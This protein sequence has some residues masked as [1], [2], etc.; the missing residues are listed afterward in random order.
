MSGWWSKLSFLGSS[1]LP[2]LVSTTFDSTS[3]SSTSTNCSSTS[4]PITTTTT[5]TTPIT[6]TTIIN[7]NYNNNNT[8]PQNNTFQPSL[9]VQNS[10]QNP[11]TTNVSM[12]IDDEE[13]EHSTVI[14]KPPLLNEKIK[15]EKMPKYEQSTFIEME[16]NNLYYQ[17]KAPCP[18][19]DKELIDTPTCSLDEYSNEQLNLEEIERI[20]IIK[21]K[22]TGIANNSNNLE[23]IYAQNNVIPGRLMYCVFGK[24]L[25]Q[26][27]PQKRRNP[28][29]R[30]FM[31]LR[32]VISVT[33]FGL[34]LSV[35]LGPF[36]LDWYPHSMALVTTVNEGAK[37]G[38]AFA[39]IGDHF[40][41]S[42]E[43]IKQAL[44]IVAN[45]ICQYNGTKWYNSESC[46]SIHFVNDVFSNLGL[47]SPLNNHHFVPYF[48]NNFGMQKM[49]YYSSKLFD[50]IAQVEKRED[51]FSDFY[52]LEWLV[53][54]DRGELN[55]FAWFLDSLKYF[56]TM[57]GVKDYA[58][59]KAY[60]RA[61]YL[62]DC[63]EGPTNDDSTR[64]IQFFF[65]TSGQSDD[66]SIAKIEFNIQ[67]MTFD[68]PNRN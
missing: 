21:Q 61:F 66:H 67:D 18:Y 24:Y 48:T 30:A 63:K 23:N 56:Q 59:L 9:L 57:E 37:Y 68:K 5:T 10:G 12:A 2:D 50:M 29:T 20:G 15:E 45:V 41:D 62:N 34:H 19:N 16:K 43:R 40:F 27:R 54:K 31:S 3:S 8:T 6:T 44:F 1:R 13:Y 47:V 64:E 32:L 39:I 28:S 52:N 58:L 35:L 65:T 49:Y 26:Q 22:N 60:D 46:N 25:L 11:T 4:G 17:N 51:E 38:N 33:D 7:N 14:Y 36:K 55:Q 42:K 53:F